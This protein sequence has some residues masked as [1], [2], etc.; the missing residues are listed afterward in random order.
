MKAPHHPVYITIK[1][2][3]SPEKPIDGLL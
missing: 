3:F 2:G 1:A